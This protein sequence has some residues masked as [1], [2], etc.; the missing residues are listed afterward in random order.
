V[1]PWAFFGMATL[2]ACFFVWLGY[3][4]GVEDGRREGAPG[5]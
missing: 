5:A 4:A 3:E 2:A 1:T